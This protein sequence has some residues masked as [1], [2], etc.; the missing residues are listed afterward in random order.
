MYMYCYFDAI[1]ANGRGEGEPRHFRVANKKTY[2]TLYQEQSIHDESSWQLKRA[3]TEV[4]GRQ[5]GTRA[6]N[7]ICG[8]ERLLQHSNHN[9]VRSSIRSR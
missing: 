9:H 7:R 1:L 6:C 2:K 4:M 3:T 8:S 5:A